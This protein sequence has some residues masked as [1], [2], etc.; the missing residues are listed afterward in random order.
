MS[1]EINR[2]NNNCIPIAGIAYVIFP[3]DCDVAEYVQQCYRNNTLSIGG[4]YR[5]TAMHNV[6]VAEGVLDR[7]KFPTADS[8]YGSPVFWVR[9]S[10]YNRPVVI[11]TIPEGG[12]ANLLF[13]GQQGIRQEVD[14]RL[15]ELFLDALNSRL[16]LTALGDSTNPSEIIIKASSRNDGGDKIRLESGDL[17]E[18]DSRSY[19]VNLTEEFE[20]TINN[21][22]IDENGEPKDILKI[23]FNEDQLSLTDYRGNN[24]TFDAEKFQFTDKWGNN[25]ITNEE[26][27]EFTD[28]WQNKITSDVEKC[29]F[30]DQFGN[31]VVFN[32]DEVHLTDAHKNEAIFNEEHIQMLCQKFDLGDGKEKMVL[33]D[34]LVDLLGQLI[35]AICA[36]TVPTPNG[37]SGTPVNAAQFTAIK[38]RLKTALSK[39]SNTD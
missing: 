24:I 9:E 13:N 23:V 39:L 2:G 25:V 10:F 3:D 34:T 20:L 38:G 17:I 18:T 28:Q 8:E 16:I 12:I 26:K 31:D 5:A 1:L 36:L 32:E 37:P 11:G 35:D 27:C 30:T 14:E 22:L 6:K 7:I 29:Q 4:G 33:G 19:K 21:G 15:V